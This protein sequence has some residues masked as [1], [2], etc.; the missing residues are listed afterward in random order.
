MRRTCGCSPTGCE[1]LRED[2]DCPFAAPAAEGDTARII[3]G[4]EYLVDELAE[5]R[6]ALDGERRRAS[7]ILDNMDSGLLL[8]DAGG[9]IT[10]CNASA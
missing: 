5:T 10:Q 8:V 9:A 1:R 2:P 4:I 3:A 6:R 7:Y